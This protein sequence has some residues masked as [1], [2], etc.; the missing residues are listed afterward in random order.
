M[1]LC[2]AG[3]GGQGEVAGQEKALS[4]QSS[5]RCWEQ[6]GGN[7]HEPG[8]RMREC[9]VP[10]LGESRWVDTFHG[11]GGGMGVGGAESDRLGAWGAGRSL[12][13]PR[14]AFP[15]APQWGGVRVGRVAWVAASVTLC[16]LM[17]VPG[18][19]PAAGSGLWSPTPQRGQV[20][21]GGQPPVLSPRTPAPAGQDPA[22]SGVPHPQCTPYMSGFLASG[23]DSCRL[24]LSTWVPRAGARLRPCLE[25]AP[26]VVPTQ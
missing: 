18:S 8:A 17:S 24:V 2:G 10:R 15:V 23:H 14:P 21:G 4:P 7:A 1:L 16:L 3:V 9:N 12:S 26:P 19:W 5:S 6:L 13:A 20:R 11:A 22:L 25:E